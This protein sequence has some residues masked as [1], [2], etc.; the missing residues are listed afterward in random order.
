[1]LKDLEVAYVSVDIESAGPI[2]GRYAMLSLGACLV[3]DPST[4]IYLEFKPETMDFVPEA[5]AV[6]QLSLEDLVR[7]G[8]P[9]QTGMARLAE[10]L[11]ASV[12]AGQSPILVAFNAPFDWSFVNYAFHETLGHNPFGYAALDIK[13]FAMGLTGSRWQDTSFDTLTRKLLASRQ[14]T[15]HALQDALDQAEV[16]HELLQLARKK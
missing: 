3:A 14:L 4:A 2:P 5:L 12:P 6:S 7:T 11:H 10:W 13:A 16:F 9:L 8:L 15:H 1:M